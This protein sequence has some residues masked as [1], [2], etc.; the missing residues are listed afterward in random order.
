MLITA[1][2]P[3]KKAHG[4]HCLIIYTRDPLPQSTAASTE[5]NRDH[6]VIYW[7]KKDPEW[8]S[9]SEEICLSMEMS[10]PDC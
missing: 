1:N 6:P 10:M 4:S 2:K 3:V 8:G 7:V 5:T 9:A